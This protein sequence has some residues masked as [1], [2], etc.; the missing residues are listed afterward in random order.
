MPYNF[1]AKAARMHW[2]REQ[3]RLLREDWVALR[4]SVYWTRTWISQE[5]FLAKSSRVLAE[6]TEAGIA[7]LNA[8]V[9]LFSILEKIV[10]RSSQAVNTEQQES[11]TQMIRTYMRSMAGEKS[12][13]TRKPMIDLIYALRGRECQYSRDQ[14]YSLRSIAHDGDCFIVNYGATDA[15]W[16]LQFIHKLHKSLC[17]CALA[18]IAGLLGSTHTN[19]IN[20]S[21]RLPSMTASMT[22]PYSATEGHP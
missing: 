10:P 18:N 19:I 2:N 17:L 14:I 5:I 16:L 15:D 6:D 8:I 21:H 3:T 1:D 20:P 13:N 7:E 4:T 22:T 11:K 9:L 12:I